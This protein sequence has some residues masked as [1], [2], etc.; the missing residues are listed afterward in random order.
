VRELPIDLIV[1][2]QELI[3]GTLTVFLYCKVVI[4]LFDFQG[5]IFRMGKAWL[6]LVLVCTTAGIV[7]AATGTCLHI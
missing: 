5:I 3:A 2:T 1:S 4:F 6:A 7:S